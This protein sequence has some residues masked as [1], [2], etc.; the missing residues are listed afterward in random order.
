[1]KLFYITNFTEETTFW[2]N[3]RECRKKPAGS[4][5][6][7]FERLLIEG[8]ARQKELNVT[9]CSFRDVPSYPGHKRVFWAGY[10]EKILNGI[11]CIYLP[12]I[13]LPVLKQILL[14]MALIP[15]VIRWTIQSRNES[16]AI[17]FTCINIPMVF[18]VFFLRLFWEISVFVIVP[19]L[20]SMALNYSTLSGIKKLLKYPYNWLSRISEYRFDGYVL[21]TEPMNKAVNH[22]NKPHIVVEGIAPNIEFSDNLEIKS[23]NIGIMYAGALYEQFGLDTLIRAFMLVTNKNIELWLFGAGDMEK[24]IIQYQN[25]DSRI[26]FYGM[27]PRQEVIEYEMNA[28]LLVNP[29]PSNHLFTEYSFP[30]KTLEYMATGTPLVTTRLPGIPFE[31]F[32]YT[33]VF[34][35]E[36]VEGIASML[37]TVLQMPQKSLN[38]FGHKARQFVLENKNCEIQAK[39]IIDF[40]NNRIN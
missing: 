24:K 11:S 36:T 15:E 2:K 38:D 35:N 17:L 3:V 14:S 39:K 29:R 20:P 6:Q 33:F 31:Y 28:T 1:M 16:K 10:R 25:L 40:I 22:R 30:S 8:F 5:S 26:K 7:N 4:A 13:N 27:R 21:L 34:E 19:D 18:S 37:K 9:A 32:N 12:F 23:P